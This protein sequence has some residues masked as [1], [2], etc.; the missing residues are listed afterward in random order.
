MHVAVT[1][2]LHSFFL[3]ISF[4][5]L[6]QLVITYCFSFLFIYIIV[7]LCSVDDGGGGWWIMLVVMVCVVN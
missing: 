5:I 1:T 4:V 2:F 3:L 6:C 7:H